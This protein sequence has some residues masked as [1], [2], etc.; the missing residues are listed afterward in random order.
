VVCPR[1]NIV[2]LLFFCVEKLKPFHFY[3]HTFYNHI[4]RLINCASIRETTSNKKKAQ[5]S[6]HM[7]KLVKSVRF[8]RQQ[9]KTMATTRIK[10]IYHRKI[11]NDTNKKRTNKIK[12]DYV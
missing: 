5:D 10:T 7:T 1:I 9:K 2:K 3:F 6:G 12:N 11:Q 4:K 8:M